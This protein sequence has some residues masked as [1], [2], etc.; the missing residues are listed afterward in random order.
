[1]PQKGA[2]HA[3]IQDD[4]KWI[5]SRRS[6]E[7]PQQRDARSSGTGPLARAE[8]APGTEDG[9]DAFEQRRPGHLI[10]SKP[11]RLSDNEAITLRRVALGQSNVGSLRAQDLV[12]LRALKLIEGSAREPTLTANGKQRFAALPKAAA[13][14]DFKP[15]AELLARMARL[16]S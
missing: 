1:L 11:V 12:R 13:L 4:L 5:S 9:R 14:A 3:D 7:T 6:P 2:D 15:H 8:Q 16:L 10:E